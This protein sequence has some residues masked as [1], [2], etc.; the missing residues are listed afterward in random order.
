MATFSWA[1]SDRHFCS[2]WT[3]RTFHI[4]KYTNAICCCSTDT[5]NELELVK[6]LA[7]ESGAFDAVICSHWAKGGAGAAELAEAIER[8]TQ[9]PSNFKFLYDIKVSTFNHLHWC[10]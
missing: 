6:K 3:F 2:V 10:T 4:L 1:K 9:A 8:A 7:K 5:Q